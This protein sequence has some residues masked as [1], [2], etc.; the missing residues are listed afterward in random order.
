ME[1]MSY[2]CSPL[3]TPFPTQHEESSYLLWSPEVVM[4]PE[5]GNDDKQDNDFMDML[6]Q[7]ASDLLHDDLSNGDPF[8]GFDVSLD[9]QENGNMVP[10]VPEE[11]ME[12]SSLD[13]LLIAGARAVEAND[14]INAS[15]ILSRLDNLMPVI[16]YRSYHDAA[17]G[18]FDHLAHYFTRGLHSRMSGVRSECHTTAA[19]ALENRMPA[20]R[21]LQELSPFIKFA[22]FTANQAIL[23]ATMDNPDVHVVDLNIGEGVQWASL[24][25]DLAHNG[26]KTF[27]LTAVMAEADADAGPY[28]MTARWLPE[29]AESLNLPFRYSSFHIRR[30]EDLNGLARSCNS[31]VIISCD[32]TDYSYTS[33][34][35]LQMLLHSSVK[36]LRPKLVILI[37]DELF[38]IGRNLCSSFVE[39][40]CEAL[41]YFTAVLDS[42]ASSFCDAGYG[43][44]LELVEKEMLGPRIEEAVGQYGAVTSGVSGYLE[45]FRTCALSSF[46]IAQAKML[47]GLFSRGFGV[48]HE[49]GRLALCWNS[50]PLT[51]VSVWSPV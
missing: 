38:R 4:P 5:N 13:D 27:H 30:N 3:I 49:E 15:A 41:H 6:I 35:K 50:R 43:V 9:G 25:S 36:I 40:F 46:N 12:E 44:C 26:S 21:I 47:V 8:A 32:T 48:V 11:F 17:V 39:F 1:T 28:H 7:E 51:S 14:S 24:I 33:L 20:Y 22:H 37:E 16:S 45:G 19:I 10:A 18:A 2:P 31:P 29:F 23:E 42:L 34:I